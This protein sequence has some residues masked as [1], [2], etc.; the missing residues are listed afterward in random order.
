MRPGGL[1]VSESEY[2]A[3]LRASTYFRKRP[4]S[5][6]AVLWA[7]RATALDPSHRPVAL[8]DARVGRRLPA[9]CSGSLSR[10]KLRPAATEC[11]PTP[12]YRTDRSGGK[13]READEA[14]IFGAVHSRRVAWS[15]RPACRFPGRPA[16]TTG[17]L[18]IYWLSN[19][20]A[21]NAGPGFRGLGLPMVAVRS[22][23][24]RFC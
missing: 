19:S 5:A 2:A 1:P 14:A 9:G 4:G 20:L 6:D 7:V 15:L 11:E 22:A 12:A 18:Y 23:R 21:G 10:T 24:R 8:T 17:F 3:A 13:T 16:P